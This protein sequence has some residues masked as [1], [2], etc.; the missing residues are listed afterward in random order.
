MLNLKSHCDVYQ[1]KLGT[2]EEY[3]N[4]KVDISVNS[5]KHYGLKCVG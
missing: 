3:G 2:T 1:I 5:D 4:I